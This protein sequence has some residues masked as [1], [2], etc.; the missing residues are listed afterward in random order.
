MYAKQTTFLTNER[1]K[2]LFI[3]L[4][5]NSDDEDDEDD[6]N[7][8]IESTHTLTN[9]TFNDIDEV[10]QRNKR[11][12]KEQDQHKRTNNN[13][14]NGNSNKNS[15]NY[16][17]NN[18]KNK[19][20]K[21]E[22]NSNEAL[23]EHLSLSSSSPPPSSSCCESG[24][25]T[26]VPSSNS[27]SLPPTP[28][29]TPVP[30]R[31]FPLKRKN[32][33][34]ATN[35]VGKTMNAAAAGEKSDGGGTLVRAAKSVNGNLTKRT[36][37]HLSDDISR[38]KEMADDVIQQ[39]GQKHRYQH[40]EEERDNDS[41]ASSR[42]SKCNAMKKLSVSNVTLTNVN[43]CVFFFFA[44]YFDVVSFVAIIIFLFFKCTYFCLSYLAFVHKY[45][46]KNTNKNKTK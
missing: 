23:S 27:I 25:I 34:K 20:N 14:N 31:K 39:Q 30:S 4:K 8:S 12:K 1:G 17:N 35:G 33:K 2:K 44:L 32:G 15:N 21:T 41:L 22:N 42:A 38:A 28:L 11:K 10:C 36:K 45:K 26:T 18:D 3:C 24:E 46:D 37:N 5:I 29:D 43:M 13:N 9:E 40:E 6:D 7:G 19:Y 16:N